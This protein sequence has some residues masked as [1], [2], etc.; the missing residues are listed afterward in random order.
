MI[1]ASLVLGAREW[2]VPAVILMVVGLAALVWS[3]VRGPSATWLRT[4]CFVL[5]AAGIVLLAIC[6]VEPQWTGSRPKPGENRFLIVVDNSR[7]LTLADR[8]SRQTRGAMMQSRL[9]ETSPW[10]TRLAQDFDARRYL[11]D[12]TLRPVKDF[13]RELTLDGQSSALANA[14]MSLAQRYRGQPVA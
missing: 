4:A 9:A 3:Y 11:F 14:L 2:L 7:S 1:V 12:S 13:S 8:G 6:L 10:L 5:K